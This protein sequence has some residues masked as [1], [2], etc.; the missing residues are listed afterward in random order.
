M[1]QLRELRKAGYHVSIRHVREFCGVYRKNDDCFMTRGEYEHC[2]LNG[3]IVYD[4]LRAM[5]YYCDRFGVAPNKVPTYGTSVDSYGGW[6]EVEI[7]SPEGQV[8]FG[9]FNF[10]NKPFNRKIGLSAAIG[11]AFKRMKTE[12]S[13]AESVESV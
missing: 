9:K 7:V 1:N 13:V 2:R 5:G 12:N 8:G 10:T 11:R 3:E 6:T 4:D